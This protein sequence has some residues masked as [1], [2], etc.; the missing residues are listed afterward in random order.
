MMS[1]TDAIVQ[2]ISELTGTRSRSRFWSVPYGDAAQTD[3]R[4]AET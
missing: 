4:T 2:A 1:E 3:T